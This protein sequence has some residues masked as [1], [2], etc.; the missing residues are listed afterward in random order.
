MRS[1]LREMFVS[2]FWSQ[3]PWQKEEQ[4]IIVSKAILSTKFWDALEDCL[5]ASQPILRV[6]RLVDS[7]EKPTMGYVHAGLGRAM[8]A[9]G[10][11]FGPHKEDCQAVIDLLKRRM[12][13][14]FQHPL[15]G[16]GAFLNP[17]VYYTEKNDHDTVA[18]VAD[19]YEAKFHD[20]VEKMVEDERESQE[21]MM[22]MEDYKAMRGKFGSRLAQGAITKLQPCKHFNY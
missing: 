4:G 11:N 2:T 19:M 13:L 1:T 12:E 18:N 5:R 22:Q 14:H 3:C 15:F 16:A 8:L 6:L 20:C 9:I 10:E 17:H 21:I 7:D